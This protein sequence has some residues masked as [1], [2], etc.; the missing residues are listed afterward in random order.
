M[1]APSRLP[2]IAALIFATGS[3]GLMFV[4][5]KE[6]LQH[7][8]AFWLTLLRYGVAAL[9]FAALLLPRGRGP[10]RR[11]R[12]HAAP[13]AGLG[14]MGFGVFGVLLLAGLAMSV[15]SHGAVIVATVPITAQLVR[16]AL[17]GVRPGRV[18]AGTA[19]LAL[20]GVAIVSGVVFPHAAAPPGSRVALGD[21]LALLGTLGWVVYSRG[22]ARFPELDV[23]EYSALT[24]LAAWPLLAVLTLVATAA[25]LSSVPDPAT[26]PRHAPALAYIGV[27][28]SGVAIL[29]FNYGVRRLGAVTGTAFMNVVP[30]SALL[31]GM[32]TGK[33]PTAQESTGMAMVI[34][35]L[36]IH[37]AS[38]RIAP[39]RPDPLT[40]GAPP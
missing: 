13:L 11:L 31:G 6:V 36:L 40:F 4:V 1:T 7:V 25:G 29:A 28:C 24:V 9:L 39:R 12:R 33:T 37:T 16:W 20:A 2:G 22:P 34:A 10:W 26:L 14:F 15:P 18:T 21:G 17:D 8:D 27:V 32:A 19:V 35:A 3:W 23:L 30:V 38:Q 5:G